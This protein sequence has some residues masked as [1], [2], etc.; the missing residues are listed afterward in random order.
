MLGPVSAHADDEAVRLGPPK[1][2][3]LLAVL[4]CSPGR[5]VQAGTLVEALWGEAAPS[6]ALHNVYQYV[7]QLRRALGPETITGRAQQGYALA[8][9]PSDIDAH[10]FAELP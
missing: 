2:R 6:S 8:V 10:R 4:L 9:E 3:L 5:A 7:S 1:Q